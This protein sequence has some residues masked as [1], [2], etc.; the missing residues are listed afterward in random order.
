MRLAIT[1]GTGFIG[2]R[3]VAKAVQRY[4][5]TMM[6]RDPTKVEPLN[7]SHKIIQG[8]IESLHD[9]V[10]T[11]RGCEV[12]LHMASLSGWKD[13]GSKRIISDT[14]NGATNVA[15]AC[16]IN[17]VRRLVYISSVAAVGYSKHP[18]ILELDETSYLKEFD[19]MY[20]AEAK[21]EAERLLKQFC[22]DNAIELIILCPGEVYGSHD[23]KKVTC[24]NIVDI[25]N[26]TIPITVR[27]S[28]VSICHVDDVAIAIVT[29]IEKGNPG[30]RYILGG[31]NLTLIEFA[32]QIRQI[33]HKPSSVIAL[34]YFILKLIMFFCSLIFVPKPIPPCFIAI[35]RKVLVD[36]IS[37]GKTIS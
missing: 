33:A 21:V 10:Q 28:G 8:C 35:S 2:Q 13:I 19:D 27:R 18:S 32:Y 16:L 25:M 1:G 17:K 15:K 6:S 24:K 23:Y 11:F 22:S 29:A 26:A 12:V 31:D 36:F 7:E 30:E 5:I 20:Y 4:Q 14:L 37:K 9:C 34:P 3:V